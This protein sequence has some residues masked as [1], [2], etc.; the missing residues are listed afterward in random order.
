ME[1]PARRTGARS[2]R[3]S[4]PQNP[5]RRLGSRLSLAVVA[6]AVLAACALVGTEERPAPGGTFREAVVGQPLSLNPLLHPT[7]PITRDVGRL[8][9]GSLVR[10]VDGTSIEGDV[11]RDWVTTR[12]GLTYTFRLRPDVR[13]HDAQLVTSADVIATVA[14]LQSPTYAGPRELSEIWQ[15]VRAEAPDSTTVV[16][17]LAQPFARSAP[18]ER[19][20]YRASCLRPVQVDSVPCLQPHGSRYKECTVP[21]RAFRGGASQI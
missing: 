12:D 18:D 16:F 17:H 19:C 4:S 3:R 11:A 8:V 5:A 10:V 13:W 20:G 14:L 6:A 7:D 15:G 21:P 9:Y 2:A 1:R